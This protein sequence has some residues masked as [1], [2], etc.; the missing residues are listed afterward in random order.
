MVGASSSEQLSSVTDTNFA[1]GLN[2][3]NEAPPSLARSATRGR[4]HSPAPQSI[5]SRGALYSDNIP[6]QIQTDTVNDLDD[7][8]SSTPAGSSQIMDRLKRLSMQLQQPSG[9]VMSGVNAELS[10][11]IRGRFY[12]RSRVGGSES[13]TADASKIVL[14]SGPDTPIIGDCCLWANVNEVCNSF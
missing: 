7:A 5:S 13:R 3:N 4:S 14:V 9:P 11:G 8:S 2:T 6:L 12:F 1:R 10:G